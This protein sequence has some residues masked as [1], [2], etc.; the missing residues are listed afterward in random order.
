MRLMW[1]VAQVGEDEYWVSESDP[2]CV[3]R[4]ARHPDVIALVAGE[5]VTAGM[6]V[7]ADYYIRREPAGP[8][9]SSGRGGEPS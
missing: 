4:R 6:P 7:P 1:Q 2:V 8:D 3:V 5:A 9:L